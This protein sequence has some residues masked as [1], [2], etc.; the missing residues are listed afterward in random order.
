MVSNGHSSET[1]MTTTTL[2]ILKAALSA[3][4]SIT[5]A[6]RSRLL[7]MARNGD[8]EPEKNGNGHGSPRIYSRAEAARLLG[9]KTA[10]YVDQLAARGLLQKFVP[11]GNRRAIGV[12][13]V[14]LES[15]I[16]SAQ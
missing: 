9:G 2:E 13:S 16:G 4:P 1:N 14:S 15:L 7:K 5:P 3:D 12:T 11:A 10:R 6:Q 8:G